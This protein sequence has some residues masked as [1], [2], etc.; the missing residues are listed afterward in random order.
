MSA[1]PKP[2]PQA[3]G[4]LMPACL[5]DCQT[6]ALQNLRS[7]RVPQFGMADQ[8]ES[9]LSRGYHRQPLDQQPQQPSVVGS[10]R[11]DDSRAL[12]VQSMG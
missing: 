2:V 5:A 4:F 3:L 11:I 6:H 12:P 10:K 8:W 1:S 9:P 7:N